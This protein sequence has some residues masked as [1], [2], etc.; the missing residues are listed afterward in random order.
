MIL[1]AV[2]SLHAPEYLL[3]LVDSAIYIVVAVVC[4]FGIDAD[5]CGATIAYLAVCV[6]CSARRHYDASRAACNRNPTS[7]G[8][9]TR[10]PAAIRVADVAPESGAAWLPVAVLNFVAAFSLLHPGGALTPLIALLAAE[11]HFIGT[12]VHGDCRGGKPAPTLAALAVHAVAAAVG[13]PPSVAISLQRM[14]V[15]WTYFLTGFRKLYCVGPRW[16]DGINLQ[17]ILGVQALYHDVSPSGLN[18]VLARSRWLCVLASVAVLALQL[19][20]PLALLDGGRTGCIVAFA[21]AM[22]FHASNLVL[23]RINFFVAWCPALLAL[24]APVE[25]LSLRALL[26]SGSVAPVAVTLVYLLLQLGHATD[27]ATEKLLARVRS[28]VLERCSAGMR[29]QAMLGAIW[30][31]ELHLLG[32]YYA[33]YWPDSHPLAGAPVVCAVAKTGA[34]ERLLPAPVDFYW[35]RDMSSGVTWPRSA[36]GKCTVK[37]WVGWS[38]GKGNSGELEKARGTDNEA[39]EV[40]EVA[41]VAKRLEGQLNASFLGSGYVRRGTKYL[42]RARVLEEV[43]GVR[44]VRTLWEANLRLAEA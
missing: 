2:L 36:D 16:C 10:L 33:S 27:L 44:R 43:G 4:V 40:L 3:L 15:V 22:S 6:A 18:F 8:Q 7:E 14:L 39:E 9:L 17:T 41:E 37:R 19:A 29:R 11:A 34:T 23:W 42:L 20:L 28:L 25:Q 32:D 30:L 26:S 35:R 31:A 38:D 21:L 13:A 5:A 1:G 12:R 24:L